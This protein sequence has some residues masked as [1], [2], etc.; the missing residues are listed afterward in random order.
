M[1]TRI[2]RFEVSKENYVV[3]KLVRKELNTQ[4]H[5]N[6]VPIFSRRMVYL[7]LELVCVLSDRRQSNQEQAGSKRRS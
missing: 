1:L 2:E 7:A 6:D 3:Q 4:D 5:S